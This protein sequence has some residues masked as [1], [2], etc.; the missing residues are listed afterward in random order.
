MK[1]R[2]IRQNLLLL[3]LITVFFAWIVAGFFIYY[4]TKHEA[5]EIYD[6]QLVQSAKLLASL[7]RHEVGGAHQ[8]QID[9]D[10]F[11]PVIHKYET[12]ISFSIYHHDG[13]LMTHSSSSPLLP[14]IEYT[15]GFKEM[16]VDGI[17]WYTY[18]L[19]DPQT[20]FLIQT[21]QRHDV[22]EEMVAYI[23]HSVL[24]VMLIS[25]PFIAIFIWISISRGLRP[26]FQLADT[27][28]KRSIH[29]LEPIT[30]EGAPTET[31]PIVRSLNA[32]FDRLHQ[33]FEKERR[34]TA[35]AAHELRTP[36]AGIKTQAQVA[37]RATE[38]SQRQQAI[39]QVITGVNRTTKLVNQ[40][41]ILARVD[42]EQ[43]LVRAD[44]DLKLL[45]ATII[46]EQIASALKKNIE[47]NLQAESPA[48]ICGN[49]ELIHIMVTNLINNAIRYTP[50]KGRIIVN[51]TN[52]AQ[53]VI[54]DVK[55]S[56]SGIPKPLKK[57]VFD[58]FKRGEHQDISGSG[59][60][61][62]IVLEIAELHHAKIHLDQG[63]E[64]T[65]L[66]IKV[67]FS[68]SSIKYNSHVNALSS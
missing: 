59:L 1:P 36:L 35:D 62:S 33:A 11:L 64:N 23:N 6:T 34:F 44:L 27:I 40:L 55:D 26:L 52:E 5:E 53:S 21:A 8:L 41:L 16:Q 54:L 45:C 4:S 51:V 15:S 56:G 7:V 14:I 61:L 17:T 28:S 3:V 29:Q 58:R 67:T 48:I 63:L 42:A 19:Y 32:L 39:K 9:R 30:L 31:Q 65:G 47:I 60:G 38:T 43:H 49:E 2:S 46:G 66:S 25:L 37:L 18:N 13:T 57:Q 10:D 22:R 50:D 68:K 12:K 24:F 20:K